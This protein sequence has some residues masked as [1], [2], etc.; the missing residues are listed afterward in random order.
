MRGAF[1]P[2]YDYQVSFVAWLPAGQA[3]KLPC[4]LRKRNKKDE[5]RR[6]NRRISTDK[7]R[8]E[9]FSGLSSKKVELGI[10]K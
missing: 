9:C 10:K 2:S 8:P 3:L 1:T 5:V 6:R 7:K 4:E